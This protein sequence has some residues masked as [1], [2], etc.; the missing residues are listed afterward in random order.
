MKIY[1]WLVSILFYCGLTS[2]DDAPDV[3]MYFIGDSIIAR[4]DLKESFPSLITVNNGVSGAG[5][6]YIE[7][8][9][10]KYSGKTVVIQ[11]G[12][13]DVNVNSDP[14]QLSVYS[15]RYVKAI[16][17]LNAE[18]IYLFSILPR[19]F[20]DEQHRLLKPVSQLNHLIKKEVSCMR[21]IVYMDVY[22]DFMLTPERINPQYYSD[23]LHLSAY[24]YE[25]LQRTLH[26][27]YHN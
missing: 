17:G 14:K 15:K 13:N 3:P 27:Y 10:G 9:S 18:R 7:S 4:W 1:K 22:S 11:I 21:N 8:K 20:K 24:G 26:Q 5:I 2:C 16:A 19:N 6:G 23:G 12:T 25:H